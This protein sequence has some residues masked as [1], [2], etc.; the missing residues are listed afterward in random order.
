M[1]IIDYDSSMKILKLKLKYN[2]ILKWLELYGNE[3]Q[4]SQLFAWKLSHKRFGFL[5]FYSFY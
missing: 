5:N 3:I 2:Y 1:L 4:N